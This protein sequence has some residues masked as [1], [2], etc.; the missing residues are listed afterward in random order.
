MIYYT[1]DLTYDDYLYR[2]HLILNISEFEIFKIAAQEKKV[3]TY[4]CDEHFSHYVKN[5]S[6]PAYLKEFLDEGKEAIVNAK[7]KTWIF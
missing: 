3:A 7:V 5:G 1:T 2:L 4:L 6:M